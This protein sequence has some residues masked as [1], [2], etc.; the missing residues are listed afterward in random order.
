MEKQKNKAKNTPHKLPILKF[1]ISGIV[2]FA[3]FIILLIF[4]APEIAFELTKVR[5]T[6]LP[7]K[8]YITAEEVLNTTPINERIPTTDD[9][10]LH[11]IVRDGG[12]SRGSSHMICIFS[13]EFPIDLN[14]SEQS[15]FFVNGSRVWNSYSYPMNSIDSAPGN[16]SIEKCVEGNLEP[17]LHLIEFHLRDSFLGEPIAIQQWAIEIE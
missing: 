5:Q 15:R 9:V 3:V 6:S 12:T 2:L 7:D 8:L 17:G 4:F 14:Y 16:T 1:I 10:F 11:L 13:N